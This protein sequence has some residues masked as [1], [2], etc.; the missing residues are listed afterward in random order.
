MNESMML[1]D[2]R[3]PSHNLMKITHRGTQA[4]DYERLPQFPTLF[5]P[6]N[7]QFRQ[8]NHTGFVAATKTLPLALAFPHVETTCFKLL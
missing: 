1:A 7:S 3:I 2:C 8:Q 5:P 6:C 4:F